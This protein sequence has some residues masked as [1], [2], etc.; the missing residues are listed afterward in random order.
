MTNS[1]IDRIR[2]AEE[3]I[4]ELVELAAEIRVEAAKLPIAD[5][6]LHAELLKTA[7]GFELQAKDLSNDLKKWRQ[8]IN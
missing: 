8:E 2:K 1:Q 7:E 5:P 4:S 6:D 3:A